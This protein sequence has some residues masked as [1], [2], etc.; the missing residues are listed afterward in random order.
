MDRFMTDDS[1]V[2]GL[3]AYACDLMAVVYELP[4]YQPDRLA[5]DLTKPPPS[6]PPPPPPPP[7]PKIRIRDRRQTQE[8]GHIDVGRTI[9]NR[10]DD[11]RRQ[12]RKHGVAK[13]KNHRRARGARRPPADFDLNY[14]SST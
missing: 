8:T 3:H 10:L 6:P 7:P 5:P 12:C 13:K 4:R 2:A 9:E 11:Q 14:V 1:D